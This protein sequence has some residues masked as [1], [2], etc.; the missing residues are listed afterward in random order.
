MQ[1]NKAWFITKSSF[2]IEKSA[3]VFFIDDSLDYIEKLT[4]R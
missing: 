1:K 3:L 4:M 2:A